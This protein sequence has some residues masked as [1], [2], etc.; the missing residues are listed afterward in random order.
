MKTW[1]PLFWLS[2]LAVSCHAAEASPPR[3]GAPSDNLA[4]ALSPE[5]VS[6]FRARLLA[7]TTQHLDQLLKPDGQVAGLKGKTADGM[8]AMAF[9]LVYEMTGEQKYRAAAKELADRIVR[10]MKATKH[11]VLFIKE[12]DK[13]FGEAIEGGGPPA[14][15][16]YVSAAAY[17]LH[18]EGGR[19]EDLRYLA[20]VTDKFPWN[21][22]G[23]WANTIDIN[24]GEPKEGLTKAGAV[25]KN[26]GMALAAGMVSESVRVIDPA[27]S[28]RLK[29]KVERCV[30]E[31]IIPAQQPDGFWHYGL[32]GNDPKDKDILGYFMLTTDAL[33]NL[34]HFAPSL[35]RPALDQALDN[36][37]AF[38]RSQIAPMTAPNRSPASLRT[39]RGTPAHYEPSGDPKRGFTLG[40]ILMAGGNTREAMKIMDHWTKSFPQGDAGQTGAK[41]VDSFAHLL[42]LLPPDSKNRPNSEDPVR[43]K[44]FP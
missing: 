37:Y 36:A 12:K 10:D 38:A 28:A 20:A 15:G 32:S 6:G 30:Y 31:Q 16:W 13:G 24:S 26:A 41:S 7:T 23:W 44:T 42:L 40:M 27:L 18:R 11:G 8:T 4:V 19:N 14:F 3:V 25:N 33:I 5:E 29:A 34:Q 22:K 39:T 43:R 1:L 21:E 35:R 2:V 9:Y 17:I